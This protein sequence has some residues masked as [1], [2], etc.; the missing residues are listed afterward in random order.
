MAR[1]FIIFVVLVALGVALMTRPEATN[2]ISAPWGE[3]LA[4][5]AHRL[6]AMWDG[7]TIRDGNVIRDPTTGFAVAVDAECTGID[8][9]LIFW[10]AVLAFQTGWKH[11]IAGLIIA[12]IGLQS[13]NFVRIIALYFT[14]LWDRTAFIWSHHNL[15][16]GV[17][18]LGVV[19][20]F[21]VWLKLG[22]S[23]NRERNPDDARSA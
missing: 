17:M 11:K 5:V 10:A 12:L 6:I 1:F 13:L 2:A 7:S 20:L 19:V 22:D 14:G 18:M 4:E 15:W 3:F 21:Y 23:S 16:Q 8:P 9:V